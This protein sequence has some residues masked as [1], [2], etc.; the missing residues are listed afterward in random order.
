LIAIS[1][2]YLRIRSLEILLIKLVTSA[3]LVCAKNGKHS[4]I[5]KEW[6]I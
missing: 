6:I 5:K 4:G 3:N 1:W 2:G